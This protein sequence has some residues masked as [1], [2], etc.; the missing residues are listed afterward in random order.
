MCL[1]DRGCGGKLA[2]EPRMDRWQTIE[3][4][5]QVARD[6]HGEDRARFLAE[7]CG[8]DVALQKQVE[9]LLAQD[10]VRG[11]IIDRAALEVVADLAFVGDA[12]I[13]TGRRVGSY[14]VG[15]LIG[16]GGMGHVYRARDTS[17]DRQVA[18]KVLPAAFALDADRLARFTREAQVLGA[19]NHP[20]I[21]TLYGLHEAD[22]LRALVLE[23]VDGSTLA[24]R[25]GQGAIPVDEAVAIARQIAAAIEAAHEVGVVHRDLKPANIKI[26]P[27]GTVKVLDFGLAK[28]IDTAWRETGQQSSASSPGETRVGMLLGT[29]AYMSPEQAKGSPADRRSD[30]WAFG[31]VLYEMLT[32]RRA[33]RGE[34]VGETLA[35]VLRDAPDWTAWPTEVPPSIRALVE[36]CL[37]KEPRQRIAHIAA[38]QF[39]LNERRAMAAWPSE[40]ARRQSRWKSAALVGSAAVIVGFI[41]WITRPSFTHVGSGVTRFAIPL[42][43]EQ[44]LRSAASLAI[45]PEGR[46]VIYVADHRLYLRSM[47]DREARPI[48]GTDSA[49]TLSPVFSPDGRSVVFWS[50]TDQT[51]KKVPVGGGK[52]MTV[53]SAGYPMGISWDEDGLLFGQLERGIM[54]VSADGGTPEV[55]VDVK[56]G[57]A[58]SLSAAFARW[59]RHLADHCFDQPLGQT[60][61]RCSDG[62]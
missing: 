45:S 51:L 49:D 18:L 5:Y 62:D 54:R 16:S 20:H 59:S 46:Q 30:V 14:Q 32:G 17:L 48:P 24:D 43:N 53:C 4:A 1:R 11:S 13:L 21:A 3:N 31:C 29:A 25:I 41:G 50:G 8:I 44:Q 47:S 2:A 34:D 22:G 40:T 19:L 37:Q 35:S 55:I 38:A 61:P 26:R 52:A 39:V 10:D 58:A 28:T 57:E 15:E 56:S 23:L 12:T 7:Q 27:D 9:A 42:A 6:L 36:A 33:F 60:A